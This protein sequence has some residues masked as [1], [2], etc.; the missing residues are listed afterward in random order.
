MKS[1]TTHSKGVTKMS[2]LLQIIQYL[3][4]KIKWQ[5]KLIEKLSDYIDWLEDDTNR[6]RKNTDITKHDYNILEIDDVP[7]VVELKPLDYKVLLREANELGKPIKK[8]RRQ[9]ESTKVAQHIHCPKCQAPSDYLYKNN[10]EQNQY[11]CKVCSTLFNNK[12]RFKKD[13]HLK[14]PHC[15]RLLDK[16]KQ[17]NQFDIYK[18]RNNECSYYQESLS[19][20]T[21]KE[22]ALFEI[23]PFRFKLRYIYRQF[24]LKLNEIEDYGLIESPVDLAKIHASP[25]LLGEILTFHVNYGLSGAKTAALIYDL[26]GIKISGQTVLNYGSAAGAQLLP[27]TQ[28]F[29]Y[30]LSDQICGDETYIR[31]GGKW[32]YICYFFDTEKKI[33]LSQQISK[34]RDTELAIKAIY[35]V[36]KHHHHALPEQFNIVVDGN[37]IYKLAQHFFNQHEHYFDVTQVIGLTNEDE[38]SAKFR[39]LKQA[40]ERLNRTYK[41]NYRSA[42]GF[43]SINGARAHVALFTACFNFLRPHQSLDHQVPVRLIEPMLPKEA[44]MPEKWIKLLSLANGY[45]EKITT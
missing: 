30:E 33:I 25:R 3:V 38:V 43:K 21:D 17:R 15:D 14:C 40:I 9:K 6:P 20:L 34:Q 23:E 28:D 12:N 2:N 37:P 41:G 27:F 29:P 39:P 1:P 26:H 19:S 32:H 44:N 22:R 11:Q 42:H 36:I 24:H 10:G 16:I 18:C 31:I 8:I 35:D 7:R 5:T 13:I 45:L 4:A